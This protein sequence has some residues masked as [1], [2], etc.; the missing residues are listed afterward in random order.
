MSMAM[1]ILFI[2][3][4][5]NIAMFI[6]LIT[7]AYRLRQTTRLIISELETR[8]DTRI[9]SEDELSARA[10]GLSELA[11]IMNDLK[12]HWHVSG[13]TAL[14]AARDG[15]FIPW[16]WDVGIAV[17]TEEFIGKYKIFIE[18]AKQKGFIITDVRVSSSDK[19]KKILLTKYEQQYEIL[20]WTLENGKRI[21]DKLVRSNRFFE[22]VEKRLLRDRLYP[23]PCPLEEYLE[24][25]YG[26]WEIPVRSNKKQD[27]FN[28][29]NLR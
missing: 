27:Y 1:T 22:K 11:D 14:G 18:H 19:S 26:N 5:T 10:E 16:D 28:P 3:M 9:R 2:I 17:K 4:I 23:F 6:F 15:D 20:F 12:C 24:E 13:G 25:V 7:F 21:R 29:L 8:R